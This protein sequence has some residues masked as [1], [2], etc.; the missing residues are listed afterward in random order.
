MTDASR[1]RARQVRAK[2]GE[3]TR[4]VVKEVP[5]EPMPSSCSFCGTSYVPAEHKYVCP[6]CGAATPKNLIEQSQL[7]GSDQRLTQQ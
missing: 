3:L 5:M 6:H 4:E 7:P 2:T 1:F